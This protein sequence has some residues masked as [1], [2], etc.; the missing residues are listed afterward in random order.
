MRVKYLELLGFKS[1]PTRTQVAFP[2]G[3]SAIVGPNG[4][5]KSNI[6]DALRWVLGEQSPRLLRA[7]HMEDVLYSGANGNAVNFAE[8]RLV[9]DNIDG[10]KVPPELADQPEI[11]ISRRLYRTG[12]SD[13]RLNGRPCRL[14]DI[15]YLF[16]D[17]GAGA[18]AYSIIDQGQIGAF[19]EM[20]PDERRGLIEEVAGISRYKARRV[21]AERRMR[22]T[23]HNLE[24]LEDLLAEVD[25]QRRS[26]T[27]QAR[28]TERYLAWREEQDRLD[29]ARLAHAWTAT[30]DRLAERDDRWR[31]AAERAAA[32][33]AAVDAC[34]LEN[35]RLEAGLLELEERLDRGRQRLQAAELRREELKGE[36]RRLSGM[37][38]R[39]EAAAEALGAEIEEAGAAVEALH[40]ELAELEAALSAGAEETHRLGREA[41]ARQAALE[42]AEAACARAREHLESVKVDLVDAA[43]RAARADSE[44]RGLRDRR[45]R[46][47][48]QIQRQ[49]EE[50][51]QVEAAASAGEDRLSDLGRGLEAARRSLE[52][53][54]TR[55]AAVA[56]ELSAA[57]RRLEAAR[58][59]RQGLAAELE[60]T[61]GQRRHLE[62]LE[63]RR[64]GV[65]EGNRRLLEGG[66]PNQ[67]ILADFVTVEKGYEA[68]VEAALGAALEAVVPGGET[69]LAAAR[70]L[71][72]QEGGGARILAAILD[73]E[74]VQ[75]NT[76]LNNILNTIPDLRPLGGVVTARPPVEG[77]L[78][79]LLAP[80]RLVPDPEAGLRAAAA[81][82]AAGWPFFHFVTPAG[83]TVSPAGEVAIGD[84]GGAAGM[85][86]RKA[87]VAEL[88]RREDALEAKLREIEEEIAAATER[89]SGLEADRARI[90]AEAAAFAEAVAGTERE[91]D[92]AGARLEADR[93]RAKALRLAA[94]EAEGEL[95]EVQVA[96]E[97]AE[98][99]LE[100]ARRV[101]ETSEAEGRRIEE[102]CQALEARRDGARA[103]AEELRLALAR[104]QEQ[105]RARRERLAALT[106]RIQE[107]KRRGAELA[108]RRE[109]AAGRLDGLRSA[110]RDNRRAMEAQVEAVAAAHRELEAVRDAYDRER[111]ALAGR[112]ARLKEL[113]AELRE[114]EEAAHRL[115]LELTELRL[116]LE[117]LEREARTRHQA[118][119]PENADA[120]LPADFD[121]DAAARRLEEI[122]G[123][124]ERLGPVNLAAL[125]E[126]QELDARW[127]FLQS[128][129]ADLESSIADLQQAIRHI[130]RTCRDRFRQALDAVNEKLAEVFPLL[131]EGGEARLELTEADDILEAGVDLLIRLPGKR[132]QH[133]NLLSGGEKALSALAL[134]FA[135]YLIRPSPF[136]VLD[137]VDAPLDEANTLRFNRLLQKIA[138]RS[139]V[140]VITHNQRVMETA[141]T[142]YGVTMEEKGV[143]KLVT[144]D[145][146][147]RE[148]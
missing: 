66:F 52:E 93:E 31:A 39:E 35:E 106:G 65:S 2:Q 25:K 103:A 128:Q 113:S 23:R 116:A 73:K 119:L 83:E 85:I 5:G 120:W 17:T 126:K 109:A 40:A 124:I 51:G 144:V 44:R 88:R 130:N 84:P 26:L 34:R 100:S 57:G 111:Q 46:L 110:L 77:A 49:R 133:L 117:N 10:A 104:A 63:A 129:K 114:A 145:L 122:A 125:E 105:E 81:L 41:E 37:I 123:R 47:E 33:Q 21:E 99:A 96:M 24:R 135:L 112:K 18:R 82:A 8:I 62:D 74:K 91:L 71:L 79:I 142:L 132:L 38:E 89:A 94:E 97:R 16:M 108:H 42:A 101:Q 138:E 136:C 131:F 50:L 68:A 36:E 48:R 67:G 69:P 19:V 90:E 140:V 78:A 28:R 56:A 12:E 59:Q 20:G 148:G 134:V 55:A 54:R 9:L 143:S 32:A 147:Q 14:K 98:E 53:A 45:E 72:A 80:W 1:F 22:Q 3:I 75:F 27:R 13:F 127:E 137:E 30:R 70:S 118:P 15:H 92:A 86:A 43:A 87:E 102:E 146:V 64:E 121:P 139:Q 11:E 141:D 4:C 61:R 76:E 60:I 95:L 115:E 29:R 7:R 107:T 6:V 58:E